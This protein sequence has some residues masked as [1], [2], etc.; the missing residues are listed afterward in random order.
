M[1]FN[2]DLQRKAGELYG[3]EVRFSGD[4]LTNSSCRIVQVSPWMRERSSPSVG[5]GS[6]SLGRGTVYGL[7]DL[8]Q[9]NVFLYQ[10]LA[11]VYAGRRQDYQEDLLRAALLHL[12]S[13]ISGKQARIT[14]P[15]AL[16]EFVRSHH[17]YLLE[18]DCQEVKKFAGEIVPIYRQ[19]DPRDLAEVLR[20]SRIVDRVSN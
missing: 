8:D 2:D 1:G 9:K 4:F 6:E 20:H 5:I 17:L 11:T 7:V 13:A 10:P 3:W 15:M 16:Q 19:S 14:F 12:H 18:P